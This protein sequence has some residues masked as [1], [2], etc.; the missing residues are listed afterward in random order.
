MLL[1]TVMVSCGTNHDLVHIDQDLRAGY[2]STPVEV[3]IASPQVSNFNPPPPLDNQDT[4]IGHIQ[5][6][7]GQPTRPLALAGYTIMI[8]L[9]NADQQVAVYEDEIGTRY[10]IDTST[11]TLVQIEPSMLRYPAGDA[12]SLDVLRQT[13]V[14]VAL[15]SS[16]YLSLEPTLQYEEGQKNDIYFFVWTDNRPGWKYNPPK[17]QVGICEDGVIITYINTLIWAP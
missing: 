14:D 12:I 10:F 2:T 1:L 17:L 16:G 7:L 6:V 9:P 8:N 4:V 11:D 15:R 5:N 13:A 3:P